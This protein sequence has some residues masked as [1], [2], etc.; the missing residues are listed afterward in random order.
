MDNIDLKLLLVFDE[1]YKTRSISDAA[2]NL[3]LGQPAVSMSLG[4][5][6]Q[7]YNDALFVRT[8]DGMAP[9]PHA[10]EII[11]HIRSAIQLLD[12]CLH[13]QVVFD[14]SK[15][16]RTFTLSMADVGA[17][18]VLPRLVPLL[19]S[20][21]PN[22]KLNITNL[23]DETPGYLESGEVDLAVGFLPE[24]GP[25][26]FQQLLLTD[27]HVVLVCENHPR[28]K[29]EVTMEQ[30]LA[31]RHV[32]VSFKGTSH[33]I[34]DR[35]LQEM[36]LSRNIGIT[37][38]NFLGIPAAIRNTELL[39]TVP[40]RYASSLQQ[41]GGFRYLPLPFDLPPYKVMQHWHERYLRD[42]A[43]TWMREVMTELFRD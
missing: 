34:V 40:E 5:L 24:L 32:V 8:S 29:N 14:P 35:K 37:I 39:A 9:T 25:G 19:V 43:V 13:H 28:V 42:P 4:K 20:R 21:A 10:D 27:Q 2:E 26:F 33:N 36:K 11:Q 12:L 31:E 18:V 41:T 6:R 30:F 23:S 17:R 7:H 15:S 16:T 3:E 38:P 22:A 1:I